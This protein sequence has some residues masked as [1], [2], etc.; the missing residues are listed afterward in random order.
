MCLYV[1]IHTEKGTAQKRLHKDKRREW[2]FPTFADGLCG[3]RW[4]TKRVL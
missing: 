1:Y 3:D 2:E 4:E